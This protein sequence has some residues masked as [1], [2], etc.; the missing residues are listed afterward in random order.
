MTIPR[1]AGA[2]RAAWIAEHFRQMFA[3]I[4]SLVGQGMA[5]RRDHRLHESRRRVARITSQRPDRAQQ[6]HAREACLTRRRAPQSRRCPQR[7]THRSRPRVLCGARLERTAR[8]R[9]RGGRSRETVRPV[10]TAYPHTSPLR[11]QQV[12]PSVN[13]V[14]AGCPAPMARWPANLVVAA[15]RTG[16]SELSALGTDPD[17]AGAHLPGSRQP[18]G[19]SDGAEGSRVRPNRPPNAG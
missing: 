1:P 8:W 9:G 12:T 5:H 11:P 4:P 7:V 3:S 10:G 14:A 13:G 17:R 18:H 19:A 15:N 2:I 6:L 16:S